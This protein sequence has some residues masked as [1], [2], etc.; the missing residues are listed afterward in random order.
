MQANN[1]NIVTLAQTKTLRVVWDTTKVQCFRIYKEGSDIAVFSAGPEDI[2]EWADAPKCLRERAMSQI[3]A[4]GKNTEPIMVVGERWA[5]FP[6]FSLC[7]EGIVAKVRELLPAAQEAAAAREA[8]RKADEEA[9]K[10]D[11]ARRQDEARKACPEGYEACETGRWFDG[12]M[13]C[14]AADGTTVDQWDTLDDH[15]C[16]IV[17]VTRDVL[18]AQRARDAETRRAAEEQRKA[19]EA[20][21]EADA[22]H[23]ADCMAQASAT[24]ERVAIRSYSVPCRDPR[25]ECDLDIATVWAMPDG[26]TTTTYQHTW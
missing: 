16:G 4:A 5:G 24:G 8:A 14:R 3:R 21:A 15:G 13:A 9:R 26:S 1:S 12:V 11:L 10:A 18:E 6:V 17:Y 23:A 19:D 7:S 20:K 25:E 22:R 2:H